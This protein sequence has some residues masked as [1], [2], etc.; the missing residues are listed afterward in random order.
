MGFFG[1]ASREV[2][3]RAKNINNI[4][5]SRDA[6]EQA[7][8]FGNS[9]KGQD[10]ADIAFGRK[11]SRGRTVEEQKQL[12]A[13]KARAQYI[14]NK[15]GSEAKELAEQLK[16]GYGPAM[17]PAQKADIRERA[18]TVNDEVQQARSIMKQDTSG[19]KQITGMDRLKAAGTMASEYYIGGS[20][21]QMAARI[22]GTAG[23]IIGLN[24]GLDALGN[25]GSGGGG[26]S[27]GY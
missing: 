11:T 25:M 7:L 17:S 10:A 16:D 13:D 18:R 6:S 21:K 15:K 27:S 24:V 9:R 3:K 14:V 22:G 5:A 1:R 23:G 26:S 20:G 12:A 2:R 4:R 19:K 8:F